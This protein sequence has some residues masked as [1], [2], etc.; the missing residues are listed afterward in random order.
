MK[1]V[2]TGPCLALSMLS[3][4]SAAQSAES[5]PAILYDMGGKFDKS[6]NENAFNGMDR[7]R[8]ETGVKVAEF[9][10]NRETEREQALRTFARQGASPIVVV[11]FAWS[12][13]LKKVAAQYPDEKFVIVDSTVDEP[14]VRSIHFAYHE[15]AFVVG[16]LAGLKSK[17]GTVGFIGGMDIPIIRSF[18]CGHPTRKAQHLPKAPCQAGAI[19]TLRYRWHSRIH[20]VLKPSVSSP[21]VPIYN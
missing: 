15:A 5:R 6:F 12:L 13:P 19:Q 17:T 9:E 7:F 11:G 21:G 16:A 4:T 2:A 20:R 10:I 8:K 1:K 18:E 3:A 14:N